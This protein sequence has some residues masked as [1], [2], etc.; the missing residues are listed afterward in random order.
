MKRAIKPLVL[1]SIGGTLYMLLEVIWKQFSNGNIHWSMGVIG[2]FLFL[3]IGYFNNVSWNV[4]LLWQARLGADMIMFVEL[5]TGYILNIKLGLGIWDYS[6][7]P[8]NFYGQICV[9]FW[10]LWHLISIV[11]VI[12]D[13]YLRYWLW[14]E[15]KPH[16]TLFAW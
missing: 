8:L 3:L 10:I 7:I 4:P 15:P 13:D 5:I 11:A 16:Y 12:L 14:N 9:Q 2:G 6:N 1:F